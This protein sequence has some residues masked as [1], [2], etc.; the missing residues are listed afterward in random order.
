MRMTFNWSAI[1]Y[2]FLLPSISSIKTNA[3]IGDESRL[4]LERHVT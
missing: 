2:L 3:I 4:C 1:S